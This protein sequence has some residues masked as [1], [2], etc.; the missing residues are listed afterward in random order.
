M[1]PVSFMGFK[2]SLS[3]GTYTNYHQSILFV[4]ADKS[5]KIYRFIDVFSNTLFDW[6]LWTIRIESIDSINQ[7]LKILI[8]ITRWQT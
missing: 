7:H 5:I 3:T 4:V 8:V 2:Q 6:Y 1:F